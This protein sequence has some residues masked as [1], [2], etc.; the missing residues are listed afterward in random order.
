[1]TKTEY[2]HFF[3]KL[4]GT[5]PSWPGDM[6]DSEQAVMGQHFQYLSR[7][8]EEGKVLM[9]GPCFESPPFGMVIIRATDEEEALAILQSDPS[10]VAGLHSANCTEFHLSL[11][12]GDR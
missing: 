6:T 2:K 8:V 3:G 12:A 7:L 10:V 1:M 11:W 9:A 4:L 5:R